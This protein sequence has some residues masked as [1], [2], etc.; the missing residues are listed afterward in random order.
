MSKSKAT[1][2]PWDDRTEMCA[3]PIMLEAAIA[4][5]TGFIY[6]PVPPIRKAE[7]PDA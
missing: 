1:P 3:H 5:R 4:I 2:G 7:R 6:D